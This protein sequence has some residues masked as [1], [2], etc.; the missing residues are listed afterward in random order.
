[1]ESNVKGPLCINPRAMIPIRQAARGRISCRRVAMMDMTRVFIHGLDSSSRGTKGTFFRERYPEMI[2]EDF[3]GP[4]EQRMAKL[5]RCL[6][7]KSN[8][9]LVGSSYGG[10][11]AALFACKNGS[12]TRRLV[13]LAPAL[14]HGNFSPYEATPLELPVTLYHGRQDIVVP[15]EPTRLIAERLFRNLEIHLVDDDHDLHRVFPML[16][17][18]ML[19]EME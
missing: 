11:M 15:P 4:L 3:S 14:D 9:I 10:L 16:D 8:L 13:L 19:L 7:A 1:M 5:E 18:N 2:G 12:R 17:W 6:G